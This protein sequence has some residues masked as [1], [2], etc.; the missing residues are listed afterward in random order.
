MRARPSSR[1][2]AA[3]PATRC[4]AAGATAK[5]GPDLDKLPAEAQK[6]GQPVED[7]IR[8]S[9]VDPNAYIEPGYP[10]ERDAGDVRVAP[11]QQLDDARPYLVDSSKSSK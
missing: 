10:Q 2:T 6:A 4:T 8:E 9:I 11:K 1:T 3:A 5:V 7:F